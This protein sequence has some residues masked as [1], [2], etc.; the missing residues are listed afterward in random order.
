VLIADLVGYTS[1]SGTSDPE[2]MQDALS[3]CFDRLASEV[4]R[5][6]G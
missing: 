6:G 2:E 5:Y 3:L 4:R 1:V